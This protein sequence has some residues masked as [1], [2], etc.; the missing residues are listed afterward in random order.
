MA[1]LY[2][3]CNELPIHNFNEIAT[4]ND[5]NYLKVNKSCVVSD[6]EIEVAWL[7]I[8]DE[9]FRLSKNTLALIQLKKKTQLLFLHKKLQVL[10]AIRIC[11]DKGLNVDSEMKEYRT[12]KTKIAPHIGLIMNDINRIEKS[13]P[14]ETGIDSE[15]QFDDTLAG[16][17]KSGFHINRFTTTVSEWCSILNLIEKQNKAKT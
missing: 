6:E 3:K 10:Q 7:G 14:K 1:M 16:I 9:Y 2:T 13:F 15:S 4:N 5:F 11:L 17:L 8:L 12:D